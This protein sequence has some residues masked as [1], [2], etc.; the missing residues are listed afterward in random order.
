MNPSSE[1]LERRVADLENRLA[2]MRIAARQRR[3]WRAATVAMLIAIPISAYALTLPNSFVNGTIADADE[4]NANFDAVA[5]SINSRLTLS[6]FATSGTRIAGIQCPT[7][8]LVVSGGCKTT[9]GLGQLMNSYKNANGWY[10]ELSNY[11]NGGDEP[12][13]V[14]AYCAPE[15]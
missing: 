11:N 6:T 12:V 5:A 10:C 3:R 14:E 9:N 7:G 1:E 15:P 8:M 2:S 13:T 4:V